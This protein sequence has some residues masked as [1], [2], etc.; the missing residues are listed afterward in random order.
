MAHFKLTL[1]AFS[2]SIAASIR[3]VVVL[4]LCIYMLNWEVKL[5]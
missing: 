5:E 2:D 4:D 3:G 1:R